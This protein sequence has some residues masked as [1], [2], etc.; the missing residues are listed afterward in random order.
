[1]LKLIIEDDE[2]RKTVVPF[3]RDEITIGR[4]EGNTIRLTERNVSR[5]HAR[6]MRQNG[7]ILVEDLGSYNGIRINGDKIQGQ[8]QV[9]EGD[10]IQI[11]DY[12]LAVQRDEANASATPTTP[13]SPVKGANGHGHAETP[14]SAQAAAPTM[15]LPELS[16]TMPL[17]PVVPDEPTP[18]AQEDDVSEAAAEDVQSAPSSVDPD[19]AKRQST[20]VIRMDQVEASR[21][22]QIV[23]IDPTEAPRLV[24]L[25]T[26]FAGREFACIRSEL[27]IGRFDDNDIALDH[28]SLSRTHC[29][30]VREDS[31]EWKVIDMQS[32]NGLMVNG[33]SYAQTT[34]RSGD[35]IELGHLK[36]KFVG[37][38]E[39]FTLS[40]TSDGV[41][42]RSGGSKAPI[43]AVALL[44]LAAVAAG[45]YFFVFKKRHTADPGPAVVDVTPENPQEKTPEINPEENPEAAAAARKTM[46]AEADQL[47]ANG[48]WESARKKLENIKADGKI[49]AD[50]QKKIDRLTLEDGWKRALDEAE[51]AISKDELTKA[52]DLIG[53]ADKTVLLKGRLS[54]LQKRLNEATEQKINSS[55]PPP[56]QNNQKPPDHP[57]NNNTAQVN[58]TG[59]PNDGPV[60][61]KLLDE[62]RNQLKAKDYA[63]AKKSFTE[64]LKV[65][66]K[67][68]DC[69]KLLG[70]A[71]AKLNEPDKSVQ[72]Y[73]K[74]LQ[75]APADD[76]GRAKVKDILDSVNR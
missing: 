19:T 27:K 25:N 30:V 43:A 66:P 47:I 28:R 21:P 4:Q 24:V 18:T 26:E 10:L 5:R 44:V 23:D 50:A 20:A 37:P 75:L 12:D 61:K 57:A 59:N 74:Y 8:V 49:T 17:L 58:P 36:M 7:H 42:V 29:K 76:P 15:K 48:D 46:M 6:L 39:S 1:M 38:G 14:R 22:R 52:K 55:K 35:V 68:W 62:G 60:V 33:E 69:A 45:V 32:A 54:E 31:G 56:D 53:Q 51:I 41:S 64:C 13:L 72:N 65:E 40:A 70:S 67:A 3:V 2:G 71:Y 9:N 63:G 16:E 11:G 73:Q 34:L